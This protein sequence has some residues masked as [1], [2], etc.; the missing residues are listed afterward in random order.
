MPVRRFCV[1]LFILFANK[2]ISQKYRTEVHTDKNGYRYEAVTN[3]PTG[4]RVYT[5]K[6]GMK[7]YLA[8]N[9]DEP[10]IQYYMGVKAGSTYDPANNT[11]LAH[12]LEHILFNGT[13]QVGS[14][15]WGKEKPLLEKVS[16]LFEKHKAEKDPQ[17]KK[18]IYA[19]IDSLSLVAS[20]YGIKGEYRKLLTT[21]GAVLINGF[22]NLEQ[23]GYVSLIPSTSLEKFLKL[24]SNRFSKIVPRAFHTELEIVY[25]EFNREQDN[26]FKNK[27][28]TISN[29]LYKNH[30]YG[31]QKVIGTPE[32]LKNPSIVAI[33]EYFNRYYVPNNMAIFLVG[34]L[35][36]EK[37]IRFVD[38]AFGQYKAR[39]VSRPVFQK[40]DPINNPL[41]SE[42]FG[43]DEESV[44]I[45]FRLDGAK[46][47]DEKFII[48]TD[49]MLANGTGGLFD[50]ELNAK[51]K[52][53][54]ASSTTIINNESGVL[55]LDGYPK[56]GQTLEEVK[57]LMLVQ[58]E[59]IKNGEF[60]EELIM[61]CI[62]DLKLRQ[63]QTFG[64]S[65]GLSAECFSSFIRSENWTNVLSRMDEI[66]KISKKQLVEFAKKKFA[67]NYAVVYKRKGEAKGI[68]KVENPKITPILLNANEE[69]DF[70]KKFNA[71]KVESGQPKFLDFEKEIKYR[72]LKNG[73]SIIHIPNKKNNLFEL[74]LIFD[75]GKDNNA[76]IPIAISYLIM[77]GTSKYSAA[78]LKWELYKSGLSFS[79][80]SQ[81]TVTTIHLEGLQEN[82]EKGIQ[83]LDHILENLKSDDESFHTY[84]Q[85]ILNSRNSQKNNRFNIRQALNQFALYGENSSL[86]NIP[87]E[88]EIKKMNPQELTEIIKTLRNYAHRILYYGNDLPST[89]SALNKFYHAP[90]PIKH[91]PKATSYIK[92]ETKPI[93][94]LVNFDAAQADV[95]LIARGNQFNIRTMA[96]SNMFN[97]Y[98]E[99]VAH[100]EIRE[101]RS[102]AYVNSAVHNMSADSINYN[103]FQL[104][105]GTQSNKLIEL[106][107][108]MMDMM[109]MF[110][111]TSE[112][113]NESKADQLKRYQAQRIRGTGIFWTLED[114]KKLGIHYDYNKDMYNAI[115]KMGIGDMKSFYD[116][117]IRGRGFFILIIANKKDIDMNAL[118]QYGKI[119]EIEIDYLFNFR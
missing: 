5:L 1:L 88:D 35:D 30:P 92:Q 70:A 59:R 115:Q 46:S 11:G 53:K 94:Y 55:Y 87:S 83:L 29:L 9:F 99:K 93:I 75:A 73:L 96:P 109:K 18:N 98:I 84:V 44:Y 104:Y 48:L 2:A 90:N 15:D 42:I 91:F 111:G 17:R 71:I 45:G 51:Q 40:E 16:A 37:T 23:T 79:A 107:N 38:N 67:G 14:I 77:T 13:D 7:V 20:Q 97:R 101:A 80:N 66:S 34:D 103:H 60:D 22:T 85:N 36:F 56:S 39:E 100:N 78:E 86:R 27:F 106:L 57:E 26:V 118:A 50:V 114:L 28:Y 116:E 32:H 95:T 89:I 76:K 62:N 41:E 65:R 112:T 74:E 117:N 119:K 25:E 24:E 58:I 43:P 4:L 102:L 10:R 64:S 19:E 6:N 68:V 69:S 52:V 21:L 12:Y 108:V 110:P 54:R 81:N 31:T 113:Y 49:M 61:A 72:Q 63:T 82:F 47:E 3:D 8:Q 33:E 105:A